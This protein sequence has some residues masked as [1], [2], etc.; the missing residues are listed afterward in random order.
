MKIA[1][2]GASR[3]LGAELS[4]LCAQTPEVKGTLLISRKQENL[5][6][7]KLR[8]APWNEDDNRTRFEIFP[9]DFSR[10]QEQERSLQALK[11]FSPTHVFYMAGGGPYGTFDS[12]EWKDH[13]WA[14]QVNLL[15]PARLALWALQWKNQHSE[16]KQLMYIGSSVAENQADPMAASYA[17]AKSGLLGLYRSLIAEGHKLDIRLFSPGYMDTEL[18]PKG[19]KPRQQSGKLW[20]PEVVASKLW[21]WSQTEDVHGHRSLTSFESEESV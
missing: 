10:E 20:L 7:L 8:L 3:G 11:R 19:A 13:M 4:V 16:F 6:Q 17:S 15:F 14:Y 5:A 21:H 18:L 12:K 2:L 9:S 1:I